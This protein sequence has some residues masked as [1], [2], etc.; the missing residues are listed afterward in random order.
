MA[1]DRIL[2]I[3]N[4][5]PNFVED[6][7]HEGLDELLGPDRVICYP[8]KDYSSFQYNLQPPSPQ[9][10][11]HRDRL[12]RA[13]L[14]E[15]REGIAG[16]VVGSIQ[17]EAV[18]VWETLQV[19]FPRCP[20]AVVNGE[21]HDFAWPPG[22]RLTHRFQK[23]VLPEQF[24]AGIIPL[25]MAAPA[26][27]MLPFET[28]RDI[29]VSFVARSTHELRRACADLLDRAGFT[30][31]LDL[32]LPR[33]QFCTV[34]NRSRIAVSVQGVAFDTFR[35]WEIPY[36]GALLLSQRLPT[37]IPDNFV[38][39]ESA[40]F[41]DT[42]PEMMV[43]IRELLADPEGLIRIAERGRAL[44]HERH[45]AVARAR[46]LLEKMGLPDLSDSGAGARSAAAAGGGGG[47]PSGATPT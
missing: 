46:Y 36:H 28:E 31:L 12:G 20:V 15:M 38:D 19:R 4:P 30:V 47:L 3:T 2:F 6:I 42:P 29:D 16:V 18:S 27:A 34:L 44:A 11:L 9:N 39:G 35:Y 40:V 14:L 1:A 17:P 45:T 8:Y 5:R 21:L 37:V 32:P 24:R 10:E 41:F 13:H 23:D 33:E 26:R 7:L 25:P 22:I 43:K